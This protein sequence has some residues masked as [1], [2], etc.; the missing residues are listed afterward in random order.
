MAVKIGM[1]GI[2]GMA[3]IRGAKLT[4]LSTL[5]LVYALYTS[6]VITSKLYMTSG[7][8]VHK[9]RQVAAQIK[10]SGF[11][12][13]HREGMYMH[14]ILILTRYSTQRQPYETIVAYKSSD[15]H[16]ALPICDSLHTP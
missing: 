16:T 8:D 5:Y 15:M 2:L 14:I 11:L 7:Y 6:A 13:R 4:Q 10:K 3:C 9:Y 1:V 12:H